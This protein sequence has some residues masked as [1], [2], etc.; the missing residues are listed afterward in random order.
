MLVEVNGRL[1]FKLSFDQNF[2]SIRNQKYCAIY[3]YYGGGRALEEKKFS[4]KKIE[5]HD[6]TIS[7]FD[8][9]V[10]AF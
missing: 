5:L 9:V 8:V 2:A 7:Q 10:V 6:F 1:G 4:P 3:N